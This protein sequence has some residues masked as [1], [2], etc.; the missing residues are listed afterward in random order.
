[1]FVCLT[2]AVFLME[3]SAFGE[4]K[5]G[6]ED[7]QV[8]T[9]GEVVISAEKG[10]TVKDVSINNVMTQEEIQATDAKTAAE[11][12]AY[13]PGVIVSTG[14]KQ[15]P[16]VS[17]QGFAQ[18]RVLILI[19]GV[20]YYETKYGKLD[21]NQVPADII[22]KIEVI[23]GA[24]SVIY[25]ANAEGGVVNII[26][27]KAG[28]KPSIAARAELSNDKNGYLAS[29]SHG[30]KVGKLSYWLNYTHRQWDAWRLSDDFDSVE[31]SIIKRGPGGGTTTAVLED[32]GYFRDNS[33]YKNDSIWAKV[34]Y[35]DSSDSQY[36]VNMHY[37]AT[38]KGI[39]PSMYE[40]RVTPYFSQ[41]AKIPRYDDWGI[42]L[43]GRQ[44][45]V[46]P[47]TLQGTLFYHRHVDDYA[48]Y[49]D[50]TYTDRFALSRYRDYLAGGMLLSE[51]R[52]VEWNLMRLAFHYKGD[53][54]EQRDNVDEPY[55]KSF[56]YTGS[57]GF[58]DDFNLIKNLSI[59]GGVSY[60]WFKVD[61]VPPGETLPDTKS[62]F[63]PMIGASYV[64]PDSTRLFASIAR[65]TRFPT[66]DQLYGSNGNSDLE[67]ER[68]TNYTLGASKF[69]G[70]LL[71]IELAPFYHD[72]SDY[73][74]TDAPPHLPGEYPYRNYGKI[75]LY[76]FEFTSEF[77]PMESLV[78][79]LGYTYN[80]ARN[81][82]AE[83][84]TDKVS[85]I[86]ENKVDLGVAYVVPNWKT[87]FDLNMIY[88]GSSY[89]QVPSLE[90]PDIPTIK[91][92]SYTLF[93]AK[94]TQPFLDIC[95][96]YVSAS[97]LFDNDYQSEYGFPG[98]GR[99]VWLGFKVSYQ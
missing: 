73:I 15:E 42:D 1:M 30:M 9:L 27:K 93:Q 20:P 69:F 19:D 2:M 86:P 41:F 83:R 67:A 37:S 46:E 72:I 50:E 25:G 29:L 4:S 82:S 24:P 5:T 62:E 59:V 63:N 33:K 16:G 88:M 55:E 98:P 45:I 13:V 99:T 89:Y 8:Y 36:Y 58:E 81:K 17:I 11:A 6:G 10:S 40:Q 95:E 28:E 14:R 65:K 96:V 44:K 21:L 47:L 87:R 90:D 75:A 53:S 7:Y 78:F 22:A 97:N 18:N 77:H 48:S 85:N 70:K 64:L 76:G 60:D 84:V 35:E 94:I 91:Q 79:R 39:P 31:G 26:T 32:G 56:S 71:K 80:R 57:V 74:T 3:G 43:S 38:E 51:Y 12:L 92:D 68:S 52:P 54:H 61:D 34:G 66:L 49:P 23:K